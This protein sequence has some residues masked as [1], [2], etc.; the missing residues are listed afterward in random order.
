MSASRVLLCVIIIGWNHMALP[1]MN[2]ET[3]S[4]HSPLNSVKESH[5]SIKN[6]AGASAVSGGL[7]LCSALPSRSDTSDFLRRPSRGTHWHGP[8]SGH[9]IGI[10]HE[11]GGCQPRPDVP[12]QRL[13]GR[14]SGGRAPPWVQHAK[15]LGGPSSPKRG[16]DL[17]RKP[18]TAQHVDTK[19]PKS[20]DSPQRESQK[21]AELQKN[22]KTPIINRKSKSQ[23]I[24]LQIYFHGDLEK[25]AI[26]N[27]P[28]LDSESPIQY[29]REQESAGTKGPTK[30][31][32]QGR[33]IPTAELPE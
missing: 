12:H 30:P 13:L 32:G 19:A 29:Y 8:L 16:Q 15:A 6:R 2:E 18:G 11:G 9:E 26:L 20:P 17:P 23:P 1:D 21:R 10:A 28:I 31:G 3:S 33:G 24:N 22:Y 5:R 25:C 7:L 14:R 4:H 27:R